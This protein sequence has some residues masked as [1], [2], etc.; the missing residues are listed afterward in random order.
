MLASSCDRELRRPTLPRGRPDLDFAPLLFQ[1]S[2]FN[3]NLPQLVAAARSSWGRFPPGFRSW[4]VFRP[5]DDAEVNDDLHTRKGRHV[6]GS[7][8]RQR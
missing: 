3:R 2:V 8:T 7:R 5:F 1:R 4:S 6:F